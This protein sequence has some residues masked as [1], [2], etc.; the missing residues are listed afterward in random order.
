MGFMSHVLR[1]ERTS[2]QPREV[3]RPE[4][5]P[6]SVVCMR[7]AWMGL[8]GLFNLSWKAGDP[9]SLQPSVA[10][11]RGSSYVVVSGAKRNHAGSDIEGT[12]WLGQV[13]ASFLRPSWTF[14]SPRHDHH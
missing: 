1:S 3:E 5:G 6:W 11:H 12:S 8:D 9:K 13:I 7:W 4:L 14:S 2:G 10:S